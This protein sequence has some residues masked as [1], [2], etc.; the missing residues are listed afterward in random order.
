M[1]STRVMSSSFS[2]ERRLSVKSPP[3]IHP[4]AKETQFLLDE[5]VSLFLCS[6]IS[7]LLCFCH[8][9]SSPA[10]SFVALAIGCPV[11]IS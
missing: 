3:A 6:S 11:A 9:L 10:A 7:A 4:H 1:K 5:P 8:S 2:K